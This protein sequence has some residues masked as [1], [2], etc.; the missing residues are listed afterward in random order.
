MAAAVLFAVLYF[1]VPRTYDWYVIMTSKAFLENLFLGS[2]SDFL[3][4]DAVVFF[5]GFFSY[6]VSHLIISLL[7]RFAFSDRSE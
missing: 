7:S 6:I 4:F 1:F 5:A 2:F 3:R